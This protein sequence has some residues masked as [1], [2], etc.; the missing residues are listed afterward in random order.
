MHILKIFWAEIPE[1][2][3]TGEAQ[4]K[5]RYSNNKA[6]CTTEEKFAIEK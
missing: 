1:I 4:R 5:K 3:R 2:L 6:R